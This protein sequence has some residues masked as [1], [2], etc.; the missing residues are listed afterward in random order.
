[1]EVEQEADS[2]GGQTSPEVEQ[3][4]GDEGKTSPEVEQQLDGEDPE[5]AEQD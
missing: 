4:A 1:M 3:E 5:Q 2:D